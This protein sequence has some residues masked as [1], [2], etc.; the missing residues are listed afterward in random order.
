MAGLVTGDS[1]VNPDAMFEKAG[2]ELIELDTKAA[3]EELN[4]LFSSGEDATCSLFF[5][6]LEK[7]LLFAVIAD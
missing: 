7:I 1:I 4:R 5:F 3:C 6:R 2:I